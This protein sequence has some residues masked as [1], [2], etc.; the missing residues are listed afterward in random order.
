MLEMIYH[1]PTL[2]ESLL[3]YH[4]MCGQPT[5]QNDIDFWWALIMLCIMTLRNLPPFIWLNII[6][7][8]WSN[9]WVVDM[10]IGPQTKYMKRKA[11]FFLKQHCVPCRGFKFWWSGNGCHSVTSLLTGVVTVYTQRTSMRGVP[12]SCSGSSVST[13]SCSSTRVSLSS[14]R[15]FWWVVHGALYSVPVLLWYV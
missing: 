3:L 12:C 7:F 8:K 1:G 14:P 9:K 5:I 10:S 2:R 11:M 6:L 4:C 13:S 15:R